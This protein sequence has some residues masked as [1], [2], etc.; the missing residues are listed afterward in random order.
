M[1]RFG[2]GIVLRLT[3]GRGALAALAVVLSFAAVFVAN[4]ILRPGCSLL[5]VELPEGNAAGPAT[6]AQV[7]A[8]L[9]RPLAEARSLPAGVTR[10]EVTLDRSLDEPVPFRSTRF[11]H[12]GYVLKGRH[13]VLLSM[14]KGPV[15]SPM[16]AE[17]T[18]DLGGVPATITQRPIPSLGTDD[19]SY[20][21]ERDGLFF[22]MHVQL[23]DG[24]TREIADGMAA[25][26]R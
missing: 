14:T 25:S 3:R 18:A 2:E 17:M 9:G 7:C 13:V 6:P 20:V 4:A 5:P 22:T 10:A 8:V 21:W 12:V 23:T 26:V 11:V 1:G 16:R 24:I 15:A 19:V